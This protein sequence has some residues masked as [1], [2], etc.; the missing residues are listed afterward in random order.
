MVANRHVRAAL[1][2]VGGIGAQAKFFGS[3]AH[4]LRLEAGALQEDIDRLFLD[5]RIEPPHHSGQSRRA[6]LIGDHLHLA[7]QNMLFIIKRRELLTLGSPPN[8]NDRPGRSFGG[9]EQVIIKGVKRL[10][11]LEHHEIGHVHDV[12]DAAQAD[13]LQS[14]PKPVGA[15]AHLDTADHPRHV[16]RTELRLFQT[17]IDIFFDRLGSVAQRLQRFIRDTGDTQRLT[18]QG[19]HLACNPDHAVPVGPVGGHLHIIDHIFFPHAQVL[20][21]WLAHLRILRQYQ[22]PLMVLRESQL[23]AAAHHPLTFHAA[24]LAHLD[25]KGLFRRLLLRHHAARQRHRHFVAGLE[26]PGAADNGPLLA[27]IKNAVDR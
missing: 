20:G 14:F 1:K 15:G 5:F 3:G 10:A 12:I 19:A 11:R 16:A 6:G 21:K 7:A 25:G 24:Q 23:P 18:A 8:H 2:A 9:S 27:A 4:I 17:D 22:E 13:L 26:I